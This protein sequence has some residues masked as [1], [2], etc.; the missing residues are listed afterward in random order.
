MALTSTSRQSL[1]LNCV[2]ELAPSWATQ[3]YWAQVVSLPGELAEIVTGAKAAVLRAIHRLSLA[4]MVYLDEGASDRIIGIFDSKGCA[5]CRIAIRSSVLVL[6]MSSDGLGS[7]EWTLVASGADVLRDLLSEIGRSGCS[8]EV[9]SLRGIS[10]V[11]GMTGRQREVLHA[12]LKLG[13]F[14]QPKA[15]RL[16]ELAMKFGVSKEALR[17]ALRRGL[18]KVLQGL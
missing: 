12:A 11:K 5:A 18:R 17:R 4:S 9:K 10:A 15:V 14:N 7:M 16:Q 13:Y 8:V 3:F 1:D 2:F 6:S